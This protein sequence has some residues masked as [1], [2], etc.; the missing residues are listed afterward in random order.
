MVVVP[1][2][3]RRETSDVIS[4]FV[5]EMVAPK[6]SDAPAQVTAELASLPV[7]AQNGAPKAV[8]YSRFLLTWVQAGVRNGGP[9][10]S[11]SSGLR[12]C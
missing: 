5:R 11:C 12:A 1:I 6:S 9:C 10:A 7:G 4:C 8:Q 2:G 3:G